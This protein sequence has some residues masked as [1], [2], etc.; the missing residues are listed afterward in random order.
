MYKFVVQRG[1]ALIGLVALSAALAD[2]IGAVA[3]YHRTAHG[4]QGTTTHAHFAIDVYGPDI[5]RVHV[6]RPDDPQHRGYALK[7]ERIPDFNDYTVTDAAGIVRIRTA[8]LILEIQKRPDLLFTL[9]TIAGEVLN[10]DLGGTGLGIAVSGH[11]MTVYKRLQE[12]ERFIGGG[13]ELGALDR[14]G[15]ILTLRNTDYFRYDDPRIPMH[16]SIPFFTGLHHGRIY[17]LFFNNSHRSVLNFGSSN[18]RFASF[19]FDGG[20]IDEFYF[21]GPTVRDV[22]AQYSEIT[23]RMPLPPKWSLGYQQSR[24]S[25]FPDSQVKLIADTFRHKHIPIDGITLDA[26]YLWEYQPFRIHPQRFPDMKGLVQQLDAMRIEVTA[27]INPTIAMD[28]SYS[29]FKSGQAGNMFLRYQDGEPYTVDMAPNVI[30]LPDFSSPR[31]RDWWIGYMQ[32]YAD[33]GIHGYWND[34]NEPAIEGQAMPDNVVF[35]FDGQKTSPLEAHNTFGSLVARTSY[36]AGERN[37]PTRRPF[38]LVRAGFAGVQRYAAVWTGDNQAKDEHILLG[39][40]LTNQL[41]LSGVPFTGADVGGYLGDGNGALYRRWIEVAAFAP[42]VR[43]HREQFAAAN[44][45]WAYGEEAEGLAKAYIG[46]RYRLM[47]YLYSAFREA[48]ETGLPIARSLAI[49][50]PF[51]ASVYATKFQYE[52]LCGPALLINPMTS[53]ETSK[54]TYLPAGIWYDFFNDTPHPG[55]T[56]VTE[57]YPLTKL[58]VFVKG[59]SII[60][61]QALVESTRDDPGAELLLHVYAGTERASYVYYDDDGRTVDYRAGHYRSQTVTYDPAAQTLQISAPEGDFASSFRRIRVVLHGMPGLHDLS[62][63]GTAM[64]PVMEAVQA[65]DP[66]EAIADLYNWDRTYA[67]SLRATQRMPELPTVTVEATRATV[68]HWDR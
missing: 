62:V 64:A 67:A 55:G 41:G 40:H 54:T 68:I 33:L 51:E 19:S 3:G 4:I 59:S 43:S 5:L 32:L 8:H 60:P 50:A 61:M 14:R 2:D 17:G 48:N 36:E 52:F 1:W 29:V 38:V 7:D 58:P 30:E 53:K 37:D 23:G 21:G 22:L 20:P 26:D 66:V 47:P 31:V 24:A 45:P 15:Q 11:K 56:T 57:D 49:D 10:E 12:G 42:Y 13:E 27:S 44:E 9:K 39:V 65:F 46:L 6:A 25:Y 63:N 28:P 35:D 34:M 18:R 16:V